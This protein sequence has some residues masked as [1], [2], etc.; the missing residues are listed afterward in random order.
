MSKICLVVFDV[1]AETIAVAVAE[2]DGYSRYAVLLQFE[3]EG[4]P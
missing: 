3:K 1:H 4:A 2:R